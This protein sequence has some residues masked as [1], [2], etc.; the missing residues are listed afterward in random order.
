MQFYYASIVCK[1]WAS[2]E[3]E[4]QKEVVKMKRADLY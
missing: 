3:I 2:S 4:G 1:E